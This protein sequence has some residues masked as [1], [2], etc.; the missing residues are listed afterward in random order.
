MPSASHG[1]LLFNEDDF[2]M[3]TVRQVAEKL[4][5]SVFTVY[6]YINSGYLPSYKIGSRNRVGEKDLEE[7][8]ARHR[9]I[10]PIF[11]LNLQNELTNLRQSPIDKAKGG[12]SVASLKQGRRNYGFGSVYKRKHG[13]SWTVDFRDETGERIQKAVLAAITEEDAVFV[14]KREVAKV[15]EIKHGLSQKKKTAGFR[16]F[17]HVYLN[18]YIKVARRNF[19]SDVYRLNNLKEFFKDVDLREITPLMIERFRKSRLKAGNSKSTT[20]RYLALMKKMFSIAIG[21]GYADENPVKKLVLYSESDTLKERIL[22]ENEEARLF[23]TSSKHLRSILVV[24]LNSGMRLGEILRLRWSEIDLDAKTIRVEKPKSGRLRF[25]PMN[26]GLFSELKSLESANG[27]SLYVF[28]NPKTG[29]PFST[30]QKAFY[31]ACRRAGIKGLRFHDLRH[32]FATRLVQR[33]GDVIT[34]QSLLGH[35]N[36]ATTQRYLHAN[37]ERNRQAVELLDKTTEKVEGCD[38]MVTIGNQSGGIH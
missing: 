38:K 2:P 35:S 17:A 31:G 26:K 21:E 24:G 20:N 19:R 7:F 33:A 30:V 16:Q 6:R 27:Q 13:R 15:F 37:N 9:R 22:A 18:D 4:L 23:A 5:C 36:L 32:S 11:G 1:I 28:P 12:L 10:T 3:L 25:I 29:K 8:L 14:L 34:L